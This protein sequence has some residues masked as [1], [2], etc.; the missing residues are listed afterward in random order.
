MGIYASLSCT[1]CLLKFLLAYCLSFF[2]ENPLVYY[3]IGLLGI[4]LVIIL[5]YSIYSFRSYDECH[6]RKVNDKSIYRDLITFSGWTSFDALTG[7]STIQGSVIILNF[8]FGSLANAAFGVANNLYNAINSLANSVIL[9]FRPAMIKFYA[10]EDYTEL[11]RL[12]NIN[13]K[14]ALYLMGAFIVPVIFEMEFI[15]RCWLGD[16]T[17]DMVLYSQLFS[18]YTLLV[19]MHNPITNIVQSTGKIKEYTLLVNCI[20]L[21]SLPISISLFYAGSPSY[22]LFF[23]LIVCCTTAHIARMYCLKKVYS[24]FSI[25]LYLQNIVIRGLLVF[26]LSFCFAIYLHGIFTDDII[27]FFSTIIITPLFLLGLA[28]VLG[29]SS[30]EKQ[31]VIFLFKSKRPWHI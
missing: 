5:C 22:M 15:L 31:K 4:S 24:S 17:K 21:L 7:T 30:Q 3:S 28:F 8:F 11:N 29:L 23:V 13:N 10:Q 26:A 14:L 20:M 9:S 16:I 2:P 6:Y 19:V 25:K 12:F 1:D 27:R 18:I